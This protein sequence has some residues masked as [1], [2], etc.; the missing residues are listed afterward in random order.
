[1]TK[2][3]FR[4]SLWG[5][6]GA[7]LVMTMNVLQTLGLSDHN[8]KWD[9]VYSLVY[10]TYTCIEGIIAGIKTTPAFMSQRKV[11][12]KWFCASDSVANG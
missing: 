2:V 9:T 8:D 6:A 5:L 3:S 1:M 11:V 7:R 4:C 12:H 10:L